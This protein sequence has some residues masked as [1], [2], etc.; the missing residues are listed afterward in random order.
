MAI[1]DDPARD[2]QQLTR[3]RRRRDV[4]VGSSE[5]K[6][7]DVVRGVRR[8]LGQPLRLLVNEV[9]VAADSV[10]EGGI[11]LGRYLSTLSPVHSLGR[12]NAFDPLLP[13]RRFLGWLLPDIR[14]ASFSRSPATGQQCYS[15]PS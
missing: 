15:Q 7:G 6:E 12:L 13:V 5:D 10:V 1:G 8:R 14:G 9:R 3:L 11:E 4:F 2:L